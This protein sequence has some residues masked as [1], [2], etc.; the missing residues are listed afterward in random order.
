MRR[1]GAHGCTMTPGVFGK[2]TGPTGPVGL[3]GP[4]G[5][6]GPVGKTGPAEEP[7]LDL[8]EEV[9]KTRKCGQVTCDA[10]P[11]IVFYWPG[12]APLRSCVPCAMKAQAIAQALGF[13][14]VVRPLP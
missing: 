12:R 5:P 9:V 10:E 13:E 1:G 11:T 8:S 4:V 7:L 3:T 6:V 14:L 2:G